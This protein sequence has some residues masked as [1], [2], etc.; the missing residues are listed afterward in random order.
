MTDGPRT[1]VVPIVP[2]ADLDAAQRWWARLGF[3]IEDGHDFGDYRILGDGCGGWVHLTTPPPG[4]LVPGHNPFGVYIFT[5][6]VEE[7]AVLLREEILEAA[8][9]AEDKP[10]GTREFAVN[11]PDDL[12][13][14][15]GWPTDQ[16]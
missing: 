10:W 15:I 12:L 4:W 2:C 1:G 8:K 13:V 9:T 16:L 6:R 3:G 14:R 11:G 7:L 5:A